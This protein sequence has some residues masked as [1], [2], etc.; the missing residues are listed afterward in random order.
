M[1]HHERLLDG[2]P[3]GVQIRCFKIRDHQCMQI[4]QAVVVGHRSH[5]IPILYSPECRVTAVA[6]GAPNDLIRTVQVIPRIQNVHL[7]YTLEI[8]A[9]RSDLGADDNL[10]L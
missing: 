7:P 10:H 5:A 3:I 4:D 1:A 6:N 9:F 2:E 8:Q